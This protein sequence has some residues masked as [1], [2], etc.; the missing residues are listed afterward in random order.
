MLRVRRVVGKNGAML[1]EAESPSLGKGLGAS[2]MRRRE[3]RAVFS[4]SKE[5]TE[6]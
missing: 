4:I 5:L 2:E 6:R 1:S 3:I